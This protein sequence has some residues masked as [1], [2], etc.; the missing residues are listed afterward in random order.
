MR[1]AKKVRRPLETYKEWRASVGSVGAF[2]WLILRIALKLGISEPAFF[3]V[4][5][6]KVAHPIQIRLRGSSDLAVFHQIF[7][8]DEYACLQTLAQPNVVMDLG[9]NVGYSSVYFLNIFPQVRILAVEPDKDNIVQCRRNLEPY[10]SRVQILHGAVWFKTTTLQ[11]L[12]GTFRDGRDWA[13]QVAAQSAQE[14]TNAAVQSWDMQSL[15]E[16]TG[17]D[18]IDL[19]KIDIERAEIEVF[20]NSDC[21][22]LRKVRN[23]CIEL[24]G[25]DC[26]HVFFEA[27]KDYEYKLECAGELTIC[28]NLRLRD[29]FRQDHQNALP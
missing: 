6:R 12:K 18:N 21:S 17:A 5:P 2:K 13:T 15:I 7:D 1:L 27:L 19:L 23:I 16:M 29:S 20:G 3:A 26:E 24:H 28:R 14:I 8:F 25:E 10:A 4:R 9:A 22:W 11:L